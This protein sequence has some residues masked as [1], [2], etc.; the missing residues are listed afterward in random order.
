MS[1]NI[2]IH[3]NEV[4]SSNSIKWTFKYNKLRDDFELAFKDEIGIQV[5]HELAFRHE[6][7]VTQP[8]GR[9]VYCTRELFEDLLKKIKL[10][11]ICVKADPPY[12]ALIDTHCWLVQTCEVLQNLCTKDDIKVQHLILEHVNTSKTCRCFNLS[13]IHI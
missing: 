11:H 7:G 9:K 12:V 6:G 10:S 13:L 8:T 4:R 5:L 1:Y 2:D 3:N